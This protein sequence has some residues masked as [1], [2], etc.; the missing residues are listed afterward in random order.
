MIFFRKYWVDMCFFNLLSHI[1][2]SSAISKC[3]GITPHQKPNILG[4][5]IYILKLMNIYRLL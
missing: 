1:K 3:I 4:L 5:V 2:E